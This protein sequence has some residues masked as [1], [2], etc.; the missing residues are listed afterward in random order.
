MC[1]GVCVYACVGFNV[2]RDQ[3][4]SLN[5]ATNGVEELLAVAA[6]ELCDLGQTQS[7]NASLPRKWA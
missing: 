4:S 5:V 7:R 1:L 6:C 2:R 3:S